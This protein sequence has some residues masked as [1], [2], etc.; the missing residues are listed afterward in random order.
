MLISS[1]FGLSHRPPLHIAI[2]TSTATTSS[3][4]TTSKT[5]YLSFD[6]D[7]NEPMYRK[8]LDTGKE[9]YNSA[10]FAYLEQHN[11]PATFFVSGLFA[12]A[13]PD[14][15]HSL[16]SSSDFAF[17]NHSYDESSFIPHCYWLSTL[18]SDQQKADQI[19][20]T[21]NI[22]KRDTGQ[23]ATHFRFPGDCTNTQN[24]ALVRNLGYTINDGTDISGDPFNKNARAIVRTVLTNAT[25]GATVL[26][27]IGGPNSPESLVVLKQIVPKLEAE[28]YRFAKL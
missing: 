18:T 3:V 19:A 17:E 11:I 5:I 4:A 16:A 6:M 13:Y 28:G 23:T 8:T 26:M 7:M 2:A 20:K 25:S 14:L 22:I 24:K 21:E 12:I 1:W 9:W 27:H 15:M 10:L